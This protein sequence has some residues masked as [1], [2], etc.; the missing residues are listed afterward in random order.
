MAATI[1]RIVLL[2]GGGYAGSAIYSYKDDLPAFMGT[3][4]REFANLLRVS[5]STDKGSSSNVERQIESLTQDMRA[6]MLSGRGGTIVLHSSQGSTATKVNFLF[7]S[8]FCSADIP[9]FESPACP[10]FNS[11][12]GMLSLVQRFQIF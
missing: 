12:N 2:V 8:A 1:G 9:D 5:S 6:L 10:H 4:L 3:F 7:C 11:W